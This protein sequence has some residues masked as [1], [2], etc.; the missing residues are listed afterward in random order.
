MLCV[1]AGDAHPA[2]IVQAGRVEHVHVVPVDI[3]RGGE[4]HDLRRPEVQAELVWLC[5]SGIVASAHFATD[6]RTFSPLNEDL[7][8]RVPPDADGAHAPVEFQKY[9][10]QQNVMVV[11]C[12]V[13]ATILL[14][15]GRQVSWENPPRLDEVGTDWHWPAMTRR[16]S[17]LWHTSWMRC[18]MSSF[19]VTLVTASMCMFGSEYR[20][21]FSLLLSPMFASAAPTLAAMRCPGVGA[22]AHHVP[23]R[24]VDEDG[25]LRAEQAG[26]Y[27]WALCVFLVRMHAQAQGRGAWSATAAQPPPEPG[28]DVESSDAS[29]SCRSSS[30]GEHSPLVAPR[31]HTCS[32]APPLVLPGAVCDS[33][34]VTQVLRDVILEAASQRPGFISYRN[35]RPAPAAELIAMPLPSVR[36]MAK[37][38]ASEEGAQPRLPVDRIQWDGVSDWRQLVEGAPLGAVGLHML[39]GPR[40][41]DWNA[42][43]NK[44]QLAF[45]RLRRGARFQPPGD[46]VMLRSELPPWAQPFVWVTEDEQNCVPVVRSTRDTRFSGAR[47]LDRGVLRERARVL[48][49]A[50][51]D[52]DI[53]AQAGEGGCELRSEAPLHTM[54]SWHHAGVAQHFDTADA[55]VRDELSEE[56]TRVCL[57]TIPFV[58][59]VFSPRDVVLQERTRLVDGALDIYMKARVTHDLSSVPRALGG[60]KRGVSVNSGVP[61]TEKSLP[62]MPSVQSYARAQAVCD[63]AAASPVSSG[64]DAPDGAGVYGIDK[65][66]AYCFLVVQRADHY[67]MCYLW[68]DAFGVVRPHV[69]TRVVFGGAPWPQRF[70]RLALMDCAWIQRAQALFDEQQ[71]L[72]PAAEAWARARARLQA[73]GRLPDGVEQL[74]PSGIEPFIDDHNGRALMDIVTVPTCLS[75]IP[76]GEA[77]TRAIGAHPAHPSSRLAVHCQIAVAESLAAGW[78]VESSKTMCGDGMVVL[79]AQLDAKGGRVRCPAVKQAWMLHAV[80]LLRAS[81]AASSTIEVRLMERFVGRSGNLAQFFPEIRLPLSVGYAVSRVSWRTR[82]GGRRRPFVSVRLKPRGRRMSQMHDLLDV[83]TTVIGDGAGVAMAPRE[84]FDSIDD[85][86]VLVVVTDASRASEDDGVGG[87]A[88]SAAWPGVCFIMSAAW[89]VEVKEALDRAALSRKQ[90]VV[91][92]RH[93]EPMLSMPTAEVFGAYVLA[94]AVWDALGSGGFSAIVSVTDCEPAAR[95]TSTSYSRS[96][97]IRLLLEHMRSITPYWLGVHV[98]REWNHD[99]DRLS[100]PTMVT[101]VISDACARGMRVRGVSPPV[102]AWEALTHAAQL[103]MASDDKEW[104]P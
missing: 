79:G 36:S 16:V 77:Q 97:Q 68:P 32:A 51:V 55:I 4:A 42:Y 3:L 25:N 65:E 8:Y 6:C 84:S 9:V 31:A 81:L 49:W 102:R 53:V 90:R 80:E 60:R 47:Q 50:E 22:H 72:P 15:N 12:V 38:L 11:L 28:S 62:G 86:G 18:L 69:S 89:P 45:D 101:A 92:F 104:E 1:C 5:R 35:L 40:L 26:R 83:V 91:A 99:A 46:F 29:A 13:L 43:V 100:H 74:R 75:G 95:A 57:T 30:D 58:P 23:A 52:P 20:K 103:P 64:C 66:K 48:G 39:I 2:D 71:P 82:D 24:G 76:I 59:C 37:G 88:F 78:S 21:Y 34:S 87:F 96:A 61:A 33:E 44:Q 17:S 73:V 41:D 93:Q 27:P 54:A 10:D 7:G 19:P 70:E 94:A 85:P 14:D 56:W 63:Q 67:A 98:P